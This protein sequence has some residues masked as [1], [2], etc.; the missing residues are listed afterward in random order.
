M[1]SL[2]IAP[3][4]ACALLALAATHAQ[5]QIRVQNLPPSSG[6]NGGD[7]AIDDQSGVTR[8]ATYA[9]V[10]AYVI[11]TM[12]SGTIIPLFAGTP[13]NTTFLRGDGVWATPSG[14]GGGGITSI[15]ITV[16]PWLLATGCIVTVSGTCA[17][18]SNTVG[19]NLAL[20]SPNGSSGAL[21]PRSIQVGDL[22]LIPL[23]TQV[24]NVLPV[25]NGGTGLFTLSG[26]A[27]GNGTSNFSAALFSDFAALLSGSPSSTTFARGDGTWATP[28]GSGTLTP[29]GSPAASNLACW[30]AST[31]LTNCDFSGD[32]TTAGSTVS[33]VAK[34]GGH[35]VALGGSVTFS[36]SFATILNVTAST[37]LT[38]PTSGTLITTAVASL[39]SLQTIGT[40]GSGVWQA[41]A[42]GAAFGGT[43]V[44]NPS[45]ASLILS[46]NAL[47]LTTSG[48]TNASIPAGTVGLGYM[49]SPV[50]STQT[51]NYT[52]TLIDNGKTI[53]MNCGTN[54]TFTIPANSAVAFPSTAGNGSC[55]TVLSIGAGNVAVHVNTT[56]TQLWIAGNSLGDRTLTSPAIY[57]DCKY[58]TTQW[59]GGGAG[60]ITDNLTPVVPAW[61][62]NDDVYSLKDAA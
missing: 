45:G 60:G 48:T 5:A 1:R 47:T 23:N 51:A 52:A 40:I 35:A 10:A 18:T 44:A 14:G 20:M 7:L 30:S 62:A 61:A 53:V 15:T 12:N 54:C 28:A 59:Y 57:T 19:A 6:V 3:F 2:R 27:K 38:L 22:P 37:N 32:V 41:T 36:G 58:S 26:I 49:G 34:I 33:T 21:S 29:S 46:A 17:I 31:V 25:A 43:G 39:P 8:S 13:N 24:Q 4:I 50:G 55:L 9:Q 16:P 11:S 42:V 56:D